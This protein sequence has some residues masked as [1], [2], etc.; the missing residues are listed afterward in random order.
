MENWDNMRFLL[1]LHR[2]K[3]MSA[4]AVALNTN[5]ATVSRRVERASQLFGTPLFV[6]DSTGWTPT[7]AA[8]PLLRVAEEFDARLASERNSRAAAESRGIEGRLQI[9][10]PPFY[11]TM[12][13]VPE[14]HRLLAPHPR[15][16]V[17]IR[18]RSEA[19]GLGDDDIVL[20]SG[21]PEAGRVVARR[22]RTV[23][24]RAYRATRSE[25]HLPGWIGVDSRTGTSRQ[26]A[27]G[28]RIF[29]RDPN[30][31]VALFEQKLMLMR[32]TGM[33]AILADEVASQL[34]DLTPVDPEGPS[35]QSEVWM[36]Y[37]ATR[38]EDQAIRVAT[39]WIVDCFQSGRFAQAVAN[40]QVL[41]LAS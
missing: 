33:A 5:V 40:E 13:L 8:L 1:A 17:D 14:L 32:T 12:V 19:M 27:L 15:L 6:K 2:H 21:R 41:D 35:Y 30:V 10:G 23:T 38:R 3:T 4:A 25:M 24:F 28:T 36:F 31:S 39:E 26:V 7:E 29:G 20:R 11:N 9:A 37:H 34:A 22:L 16:Q 18:N